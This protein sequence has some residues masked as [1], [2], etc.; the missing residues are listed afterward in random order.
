MAQSIPKTHPDFNPFEM[1][2]R[3]RSPEKTAKYSR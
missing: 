2:I 3:Y 1:R